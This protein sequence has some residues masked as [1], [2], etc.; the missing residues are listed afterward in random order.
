MSS[1]MEFK[2]R[3]TLE[4]RKEECEKM[5]NK[6]PDRIPVIVERLANSDL[7]QMDRKKFL[8]P[9]DIVLGQFIQ[10]IRKRINLNPVN[11]IFTF[12]GEKHRLFNIT[13]L[14]SK[15]YVDNKDEDGFLYVYYTSENTFG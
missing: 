8:V 2:K 6:F 13:D 1:V 14:L 12:I 9:S 10:I 5:L 7:P 3:F 11:A 4:Q 15:I